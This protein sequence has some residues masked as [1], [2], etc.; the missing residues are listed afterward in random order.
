MLQAICRDEVGGLYDCIVSPD[1]VKDL[2]G[3][4]YFGGFAFSHQQCFSFCIIYEHIGAALHALKYKSRFD[5]RA[6]RR[7][8]QSF[9]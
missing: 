8:A 7:I 6:S 3:D 9:D 4:F 5:C 1:L 2:L